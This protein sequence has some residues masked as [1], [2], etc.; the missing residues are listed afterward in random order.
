MGNGSGSSKG[1][2]VVHRLVV[3]GAGPPAVDE[4]NRVAVLVAYGVISTEAIK[5]NALDELVECAGFGVIGHVPIVPQAGT[6]FNGKSRAE[7]AWT[8]V[9]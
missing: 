8:V 2:A 3:L 1:L 7:K 6:R 5:E 4:C 9:S